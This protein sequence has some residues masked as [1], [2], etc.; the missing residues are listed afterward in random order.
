MIDPLCDHTMYVISIYRPFWLLHL[1]CHLHPTLYL[2]MHSTVNGRI[3]CLG[4]RKTNS[5]S[6]GFSRRIRKNVSNVAT[7]TRVTDGHRV[8][9]V[10]HSG[11]LA[12]LGGRIWCSSSSTKIGTEDVQQPAVTQHFGGKISGNSKDVITF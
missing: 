10:F 7:A 2:I 5:I 6:S 4:H 8:T 11:D 3:R 12:D 1:Y 9:T